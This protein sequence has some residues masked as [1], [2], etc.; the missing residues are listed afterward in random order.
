MTTVYTKFLDIKNPIDRDII[1]A[2]FIVGEC[3]K[4]ADFRS[5]LSELRSEAILAKGNSVAGNVKHKH[6]IPQAAYVALPEEIREN[7]KLLNKWVD[8]YHPYQRITK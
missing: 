4:D 3:M 2:N 1:K 8:T 6:I 7:K 5:Y